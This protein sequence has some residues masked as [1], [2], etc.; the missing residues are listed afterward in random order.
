MKT[1]NQR[2]SDVGVT[3]SLSHPAMKKI[4][5]ARPGC[6]RLSVN[7]AVEKV[8]VENNIPL[9]TI[10][11]R[12]ERHVHQGQAKADAITQSVASSVSRDVETVQD[13][14]VLQNDLIE[15]GAMGAKIYE[16]SSDCEEES[17]TLSDKGGEAAKVADRLR[18]EKEVR[19]IRQGQILSSSTLLSKVN[20][21]RR[22]I[23]E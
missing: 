19:Q 4:T 3:L 11:V 21:E 10:K 7:T 18:A 1:N 13:G 5:T 23:E 8:N 20:F 9:S 14:E 22:V 15:M 16:N 17:W 2:G 12:V 6:L